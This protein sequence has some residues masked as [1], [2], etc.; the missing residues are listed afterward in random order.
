MKRKVGRKLSLAKE[1]LRA[2]SVRNL[3][4]IHGGL[5]R[6]CSDSCGETAIS[7]FESCVATACNTTHLTCNEC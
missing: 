7:C 3:G 2:L 6:N 5:T 4:Q 1:T